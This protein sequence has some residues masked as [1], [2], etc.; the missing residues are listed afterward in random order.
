MLF[1]DGENN[2]LHETFARLILFVFCFIIL[3]ATKQN[4]VFAQTNNRKIN[5]QFLIK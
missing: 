3:F 4:I 1:L 2:K 5:A